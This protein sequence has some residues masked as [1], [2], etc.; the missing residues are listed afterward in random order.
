MEERNSRAMNDASIRKRTEILA[1]VPLFSC[2][3]RD[4]L[5]RLNDLLVEVSYRQGETVCTEGEAGESLFVILSGE[6]EVWGGLGRLRVI[7]R[8]GPGECLGEMSL[9]MGGRRTATVT[10]ARAARLVGLDKAAFDR[11]FRN[12][13][14]V[15]EYLSRVLCKR[16]AATSRGEVATKTATVIGVT[17]PPGLKGKTLI[18]SALAGLLMDCT[19][20]EVLLVSINEDGGG[21][22][23]QAV[24]SLLADAAQTSSEELRSQLKI[25]GSDVPLLELEVTPNGDQHRQAECLAAV[26]NRLGDS[27]PFIVIDAS[28]RSGAEVGAVEEVSDF[29]VQLVDRC[30]PGLVGD[31]GSHR[32][33]FLA[34]NLHNRS[35]VPLPICH[36]EPFVIPEDVSLRGLDTPSQA[37][38]IRENPWSP[39]SP[40]LHRL[41]RKI[42]GGSV[43]IAMGGGAAFAIAHVGVLKVLEDNDIPIDLVAGSSM[44]SIIATGYAAGIRASEMIDIA[45]RI[46]TKWN[47]FANVLDFTIFQPGFLT[48]DRM[49]ALF[50]P[51]T[52]PTTTFDQ[53][54][55]PCRVVATDVETG[56]SVP[57]G[58]G[59]LEEAWRA[60][61]AVPMVWAP[62]RHQG[63]V[64]VDGG[65]ADPVPAT[66]VSEM[67]ADVCI[68]VNVV[69]R[70]RKGAESALSRFYR[71]INKLNPLA[72]LGGSQDLPSMFDLVMNSMQTLQHE[73]GNFKAISADVRI[74]P[75]LSGFTWTDFYRPMEL[76]ERGREAAERALPDIKRAL[77]RHPPV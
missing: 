50:S 39:A 46:G 19:E 44:G 18:A 36:C 37:C 30:E 11:F 62:V 12:N 27:F 63:R 16:L 55:L 43:G 4:E 48:G 64:L 31:T 3:G 65:V 13:P 35:S 54:C 34:V 7:G 1:H 6:L 72:Y 32:R 73:L 60:S 17:G 9:L 47:T 23:Q 67:G 10:A 26:I 69:P 42:L 57:I 2:L 53:L 76:I 20:R 56:E 70:P 41:A 45:R 15:L 71:G 74:N 66:V 58:W 21:S 22:R 8:L 75:D 59:P 49:A 77:A 38:R 5:E 24:A 14:K 40:P 29:V 61:C 25:Q 68:G 33:T 52:G 51:L 28:C